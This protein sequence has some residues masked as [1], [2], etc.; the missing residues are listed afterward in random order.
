M[1]FFFNLHRDLEQQ[2]SLSFLCHVPFRQ[3][4]QGPSFTLHIT[5]SFYFEPRLHLEPLLI[6]GLPR[7]PWSLSARE[8]SFGSKH[9]TLCPQFLTHTNQP[10]PKGPYNDLD[11][12]LDSSTQSTP[13]YPVYSLDVLIPIASPQHF[14]GTIQL[15]S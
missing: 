1:I 6:V 3:K 10:I 9:C 5:A 11:Y 4:A 2:A 14:L 7:K 12:I 13:R 8:D 15:P